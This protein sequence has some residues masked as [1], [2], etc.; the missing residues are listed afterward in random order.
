[1]KLEL[2]W[3]KRK[4]ISLSDTYTLAE[5]NDLFVW[6]EKHKHTYRIEETGLQLCHVNS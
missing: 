1:M 4:T 2:N 3:S 5:L 6:E